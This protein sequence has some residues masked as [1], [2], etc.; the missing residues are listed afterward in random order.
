MSP[1]TPRPRRPRPVADAPVD[2]LL[3]DGA[4]DL[5]RGW[6]LALLEDRALEAAARVPA[7]D[8]ARDAPMLIA[9]VVRALASDADLAR[10]GPGGDLRPLAG[11][12]GALAGAAGPVAAAAA[13]DD[14]RAVVWAAALACLPRPSPEQIGDLA[15]RIA[16]IAGTV[17]AAALASAGAGADAVTPAEGAAAP[18]GDAEPVVGRDEAA[19]RTAPLAAV[20]DAASAPPAAG[21]TAAGSARSRSTSRAPPRA[22][23]ASRCCSSRWT[24]TS[25]SRRSSPAVPWRSA[26]RAGRSA[27]RCDARTSSGARR[28][29][30]SG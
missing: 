20:P 13:I 27:A 12:A 23:A 15:D 3:A 30:A 25:A 4:R 28:R 10:L 11:R 21:R 24:I 22:G 6:L 1:G 5:A 2:A 18:S 26:P 19:P 29:G 8:L 7:A 16:H 14:L 9:A 17:R